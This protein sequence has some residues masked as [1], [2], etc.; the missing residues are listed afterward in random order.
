MAY[1]SLYLQWLLILFKLAE[2]FLAEA[3]S[4]IAGID[5]QATF[6]NTF[7]QI[8]FAHLLKTFV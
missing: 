3:Q 1:S 6:E 7:S 5:E 8:V 4:R 2:T